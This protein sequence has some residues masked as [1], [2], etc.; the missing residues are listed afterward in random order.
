MSVDVQITRKHHGSVESAKALYFR[1]GEGC[2]FGWLHGAVSGSKREMGVVICQP[3]GYEAICAHRGI[4]VFAETFAAAGIPTL[5]FDYLGTGDSAEIDP[6]ANQLEV[7]T[8][9][10]LAAIREL[11][12]RTGVRRVCVLGFRLGTLLAR[13]AAAR[14]DS[15]DGLIAVSP[16][17][18]GRR[19]LRELRTTR[20]AAAMGLAGEETASNDA[21][22]RS[23]G[24]EVSGFSLSAA[25]LAALAKVDASML[26]PRS[27]PPTLLIEANTT[28]SRRDAESIYPQHKVRHESLPGLIEMLMTAPQFAVAPKEVI[29]LT[30]NWLFELASERLE[31]ADHNKTACQLPEQRVEAIEELAFPE[32]GSVPQSKEKPVSFGSDSMLFGILTQPPVG[33]IRRRAVI[34][35]NAGADHHIGASRIYV[36]MA[37]RWSQHGYMVL[38]MDL[39]GLGDSGTPSGSLDDNVF[40][41][42][43]LD[44]IR[45][46]IEFLK[47]D[48]GIRDV[49]LV[50]LC[51]GAYHALRA[52]VAGLPINRILMVNPQNYFWKVGDTLNDVQLVEVVRNPGVYRERMMSLAAWKRVFSGQVN[53]ARIIKIYLRR[54]FLA[55]EST[56]RDIARRLQL[57]LPNDLGRELEHIAARGVRMVFVFARDE[58]GIDLLKLQAGKSVQRLGERCKIHVISS[59]DHVFTQS[60][61]RA[62]MEKVV[63][64]ELFARHASCDAS[65]SNIKAAGLSF[66]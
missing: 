21:A 60:G 49:T 51:S 35:L 66:E 29:E 32:G 20:L 56:I 13:L 39:A 23:T 54:P 33:E 1:S 63:S 5:R 14:S 59:G 11:R 30:R 27:M 2:L 4:R 38:R 52:A 40:P 42:G 9:D 15:V 31:L 65:K 12:S 45:T 41:E 24:M 37:R 48:H 18:T 10:I 26:G 28:I 44:D 34:L 22:Q 46:A 55:V 53:V 57:H 3:F 17:V 47:N 64:D 25:T 16:I 19:Y 58:P 7:W 61:P 43:A 62:I 36:S 6:S 8:L 50:G